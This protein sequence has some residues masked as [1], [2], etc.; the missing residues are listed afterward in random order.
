M[1]HYRR[2]WIEAGAFFF[3]VA[4][5]DRGS[6]LL[7]RQ[8][9]RL[10]R[11]YTEVKRQR[12]FETVAIC[13]LP[14]HI[15]A[16][17]RLPEGDTDYASRWNLLK[18]GFSRG[19]PPAKARSASKIAKREK[20]IWQRRYWEHAIRDDIDFE[21]HVNYIHY[22]PVKHGL[23]KRVVDWPFSSFHCYV[24]QGIVP[25]DWAGDASELSGRFGE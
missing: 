11:A 20:G 13:I 1:S 24:A 9:E 2:L 12:P 4:L 5:A 16:L 19:L 14:D 3:T 21:R 8:V 18:T 23:V 25:S 15:H 22:N 10:R 6:E 7:V 17:W